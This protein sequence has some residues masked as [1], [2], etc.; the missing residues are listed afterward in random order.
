MQ[1]A[2]FNESTWLDRLWRRAWW[3]Y[4]DKSTLTEAAGGAR[5][6]HKQQAAQEK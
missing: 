5:K 3:E 2:W 1:L 4:L 6:G